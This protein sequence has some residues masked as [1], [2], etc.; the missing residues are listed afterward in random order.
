MYEIYGNVFYQNPTEALFQGEG[1]IALYNNLFFTSTGNAVHIQPHNDVPRQIRVFNNTIVASGRGIR[2]TGGSNSFT[3]KVIGNAVFASTPIQAADQTD[4]ITDAYSAASIYL[5]N[6]FGPLGQFNL[7]PRPGELIGP[8]LDT[9]EFENFTEW[10]LDFNGQVHSGQFRG[11]YAESGVN[12]GWL[13]KLERK[14][15]S[16]ITDTTPPAAPTGL[17]VL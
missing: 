13:P 7:Y 10:N 17:R 6:P 3:Q 11:A 16:N 14:P 8:Q 5:D 12:P 9:S 4:N 15:S 1:N 2:V